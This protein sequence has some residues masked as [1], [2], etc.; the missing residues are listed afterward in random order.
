MKIEIRKNPG[1]WRHREGGYFVSFG[2][3]KSICLSGGELSKLGYELYSLYAAE[4]PEYK[5]T[6]DDYLRMMAL[7]IIKGTDASIKELIKDTASKD[8]T[9]GLWFVN[10]KA[11]YS[12]IY[13]NLPERI[14]NNIE[15]YIDELDVLSP[16]RK[17]IVRDE[18]REAFMRVIECV[19][20]LKMQGVGFRDDVVEYI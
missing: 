13:R 4:H 15:A 18:A 7:T 20:S 9:Y 17:N 2:D 8:I 1:S 19:Y 12:A 3:G 5:D 6:V 16:D 14:V 11:L 10:E